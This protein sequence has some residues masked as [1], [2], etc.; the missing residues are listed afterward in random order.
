MRQCSKVYREFFLCF[1]EY[2][3]HFKEWGT[4]CPPVKT[5]CP[6]DPEKIGKRSTEQEGEGEDS[7]KEEDNERK[8]RRNHFG[9][10]RPRGDQSLLA[11]SVARAVNIN[12]RRVL[13]CSFN[14]I[15]FQVCSL[16]HF[17]PPSLSFLYTHLLICT[18]FMSDPSGE[19]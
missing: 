4:P 16:F 15:T 18:V 2:V 13:L 11:P 3:G 10:A 14:G 9:G 19:R 5:L 17:L 6:I 12:G 1:Q 7:N 8:R